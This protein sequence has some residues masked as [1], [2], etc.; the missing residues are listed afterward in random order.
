MGLYRFLSV[1][2]FIAGA[3]VISRPDQ[4]FPASLGPPS[5][6]HQHL[7]R[8]NMYA[9]PLTFSAQ[10]LAPPSD[11]QLDLAGV[12]ACVASVVITSLLFILNRSVVSVV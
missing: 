12:L 11:G 4:L 5:A 3:L 2:V 6:L 1:C 7:S 8:H 10:T 9:D